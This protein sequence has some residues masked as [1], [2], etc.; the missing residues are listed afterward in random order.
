MKFAF[1]HEPLRDEAAEFFEQ[2]TSFWDPEIQ[3][4]AL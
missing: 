2:Y 3:Q 4:R 1:L